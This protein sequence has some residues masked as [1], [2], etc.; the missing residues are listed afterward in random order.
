MFVTEAP[1]ARPPPQ[2]AKRG[3]AEVAAERTLHHA[4]TFQEG[5]HV[6]EIV[7]SVNHDNFTVSLGI[8]HPSIDPT[9]ITRA[10]GFEPQHSW[11]A[12]DKRRTA[13]GRPLDGNY[14]ESYWTGEFRELD[15]SLRGVVEIEA[16]LLQAVVKLRRSQKF[17]SRLQT[18]GATVE[19][20]VEVAGG[21]EFTFALSP[22]LMSM[23]ARSGFSLVLKVHAEAQAAERRK[24][25]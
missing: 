21:G 17:L 9:E 3:T 18:E 14:H 6:A 2:P 11:K 7:P 19:L 12:G 25:G 24:V 13:Q 20:Y 4:V 10:L 5:L 1:E 15:T 22:Q 8:R 16:V 23:I